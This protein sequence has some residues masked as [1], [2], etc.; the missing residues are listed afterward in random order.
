MSF[1]IPRTKFIEMFIKYVPFKI[2]MASSLEPQKYSIN[3]LKT[4]AEI[5]GKRDQLTL[6]NMVFL[7][8]AY[9]LYP[10]YITILEGS[11]S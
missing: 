8:R 3:I 5:S 2:N 4:M 11:E 6:N 1:D 10:L 7:V 9:F